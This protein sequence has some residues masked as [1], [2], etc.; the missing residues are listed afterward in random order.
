[1]SDHKVPT[2]RSVLLDDVASIVELGKRRRE[3]VQIITQ[4]VRSEVGDAAVDDF[5]KPENQLCEFPLL[6]TVQLYG[7]TAGC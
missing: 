1:M 4:R 2:S 5:R 7:S 3:L 6:R